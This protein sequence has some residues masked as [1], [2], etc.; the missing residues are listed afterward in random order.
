M[1]LRH[2]YLCIHTDHL[3]Y[4]YTYQPWAPQPWQHQQLGQQ[5]QPGHQQLALLRAWTDLKQISISNFIPNSQL[6]SLSSTLS[7]K[8]LKN[9]ESINQGDND[10]N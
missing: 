2:L 9:F 10:G 8:F 4:M 1:K 5:Q 7:Y 3:L 6:W